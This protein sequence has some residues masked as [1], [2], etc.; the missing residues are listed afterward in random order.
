V[1]RQR[2][3]FGEQLGPLFDDEEEPILLVESIAAFRKRP[4]HRQKAH[5]Y[6]SAL[7]HRAAELGDRAELVRADTFREA[8][9][10]RE[11]VAVDPASYAARR[12]VREL[13]AEVLPSRGFITSEA[14]FAGWVR[15]RDTRGLVMDQFYRWVREREGILMT[16]AGKPVGGRFSYD[17]DNRQPPPKKQERLDLPEPWW[18][19]EDAIDEQVRAD[20]D[21]WEREGT[22]HF[23]GSDGPRRFAVTHD[24]A[25]TALRRFVDTRLASFGP[26]EDATLS[27]DWTMS[28][29][30][31]S[32]PMNL[33]VLDPREVVDAALEAYA[34][35]RAPLNSVEGFVR[36]I[37]G[38]RDWMWHLYW[39]LGERY[40]HQNALHA[41]H[42]VPDAFWELDPEAI[43]ANCLSSVVAGVQE[44][45][46]AHH[47]QRLMMLGN[48]AL[49]RAWSPAE[50]SEWFTGAFVD[51][52]PWVMPTNVVG[53]SLHADGGIV[54]TKPYA[55]GGAY[56]DRMTD[57][58]GGCRFDPKVRVGENACPF[59]AGYWA[60]LHHHRETFS[61]NPR[62][63]QPLAGL[64]RLK[65]LDELLEQEAHRT[66]W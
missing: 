18:P 14:D 19:E 34:D 53:M 50:T 29:S 62:M 7:R 49:E 17:A 9:A 30:L 57:Y 44:H 40:M 63:S 24:E 42:R 56:I 20:L 61:K 47:I 23:I 45:G 4:T 26:M 12:L 35:G 2:I 52:T 22:V 28:H 15:N 64:D 59:T 11:L 3:L 32:V 21:R 6:L 54:A 33:G 43:E 1:A 58:C 8:L 48:F 55:S 51:G 10:G 38:W 37:V 5:L 16:R 46:W 31:L 39:H 60:F 66:R 13:G 65:D 25:A 27:A 41:R 36:Q